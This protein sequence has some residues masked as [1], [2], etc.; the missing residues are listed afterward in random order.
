[1]PY[2]V[3]GSGFFF[4]AKHP[5]FY[6]IC[7]EEWSYGKKLH[8][9]SVWLKAVSKAAPEVEG[10]G[11]E[12]VRIAPAAMDGDPEGKSRNAE[13]V[14]AWHCKAVAWRRWEVARR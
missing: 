9:I 12:G 5:I 8:R 13:Y 4:C 7:D 1:M 11:A 6:Y 10:K 3:T 2:L 14:V